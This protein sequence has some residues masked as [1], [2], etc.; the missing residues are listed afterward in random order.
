[1][2]MI[3]SSIKLRREI[4]TKGGLEPLFSAIKSAY[5]KKCTMEATIA[6]AALSLNDQN[7][8]AIAKYDDFEVLMQNHIMNDADLNCS[9]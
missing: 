5:G 4:V 9:K 6:V 2:I 7:K 1:M 3:A 8:I